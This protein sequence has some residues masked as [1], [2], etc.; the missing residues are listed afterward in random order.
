[1]NFNREPLFQANI[2]NILNQLKKEYGPIP[3]LYTPSIQSYI[4]ESFFLPKMKLITKT[5]SMSAIE[6]KSNLEKCLPLVTC[7]SAL[8]KGIQFCNTLKQ[9]YPKQS[10]AIK[11][12]AERPDFHLGRFLSIFADKMFR[13]TDFYD[14]G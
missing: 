1:V 8:V 9:I 7:R 13:V 6:A 3:G 14:V 2:T 12:L 11:Y 4:F 5:A 10:F